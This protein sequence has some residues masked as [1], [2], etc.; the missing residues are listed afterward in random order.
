MD[1]ERLAGIAVGQGAHHVHARQHRKDAQKAPERGGVE[2][3][4]RTVEAVVPKGKQ[5]GH[6][7]RRHRQ[8][9]QHRQ[10]QQGAPTAP[11][12]QVRPSQAPEF[13]APIGAAGQHHRHR[14][15]RDGRDAEGAPA[16]QRAVRQLLL[17]VQIHGQ[18]PE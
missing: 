12:R 14:G 7:Y 2:C 18:A 1:V 17:P 4:Q 6:A 11:R 8:K 9:Q 5:H 15:H 3:L 10:R 16:P 13:P